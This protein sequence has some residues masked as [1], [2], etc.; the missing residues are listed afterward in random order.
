MAGFSVDTKLFREL[1]ELLVGRESTALIE[2][3]KNAYDADATEVSIYGRV[4]STSETPAI[5]VSDNGIGMTAEEFSRGFLRIA[6]RSKTTGDRRSP[7][8][9]RRYTGE[10][11]VGRLA[12][13]KLAHRLRI[14]SRRWNGSARDPIEGF[15]ADEEVLAR[16]DWDAIEALETLTEIEDSGAVQVKSAESRKRQAG[17]RLQLSPLRKRWTV[18][19]RK[20]FLD[21]VATL[22]PPSALTEPLPRVVTQKPILLEKMKVRDALRGGGF[23]VSFSGDLSLSD[24]DLPAPAESASWIIEIDCDRERRRLRV[25]VAPTRR[26]QE[27]YSN[28]EHFFIDRQLSESEPTVGFQ[29]RIL[30]RA[31]ESWPARYHGVRVYFEGFR[32]L[33]YGERRDDWLDLER[34]YRSRGKG[35]LGRLRSLS[36]WNLPPGREQEGLAIQGNRALF[37]AILLTRTDADELKMLV[38]REGFLPSTEFD[39]IADTVRLAIDIQVRLRYAATSEVKQARRIEASR[40][41]KAVGR[42]ASGESPSAFLLHDLQ[43]NSIDT[44][45][46]AR[47]AISS[48]SSSVALA[49]L[50]DVEKVLRSAAD[51]TVEAASEAT[52]FRVVASLGLEHAAFVHEVR[53]LSVG[54]HALV[55]VLERIARSTSDQHTATRLRAVAADARDL[56]ERL[57]RNALYLTEVTG[58]EGRRRRSR[59]KLRERVEQVLGFFTSAIERRRHTIDLDVPSELVTPPLFPAELVAIISNLLSNAIKFALEVGRVRISAEE[60]DV[61]MVLRVENTGQAVELHSAERWFEP[62]R[63]TTAEVDESLGQGMGLG[64]TIT[65]SMVDEYGGRVLFVQPTPGYATAVEV[66]FPRR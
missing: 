55:E 50:D 33:P 29:A 47:A 51:L 5:I 44:L 16:I 24:S 54:A 45:Q 60:D 20:A 10:K 19:D 3:I 52:M 7:C 39:F 13:H 4:L 2:L 58:V 34:D 22:T 42:A 41:A 37:G 43:K 64:L 17:T 32:V 6:G 8:F 46:T 27:E 63:S 9:Q 35:E 49:R 61:R 21:E 25:A 23:T 28:A 56:R 18:A 66:E 53:S 38:N 30:Q 15:P 14:S 26:T 36:G 1:G 12:A 65:R 62:F 11:G 48:G 59:Q 40:Q 31:H 57:R